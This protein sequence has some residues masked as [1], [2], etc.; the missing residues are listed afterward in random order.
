[1]SLAGLRSQ[2]LEDEYAAFCEGVKRLCKVDLSSYKRAQMERRIRT[3]ADGRGKP[4][5]LDYLALLAHDPGELDRFLDRVTINVS[6]LWRNPTQWQTLAEQVIPCLGAEGLVRAWSAGCSYGAELFTIAAICR[7]VVPDARLELRG[8]D[9]DERVVTRARAGRFS[10]SDMRSVPPSSRE[11]WFEPAD[12]GWRAREELRS[13]TRFEVEDLLECRPPVA[14]Y[15]LVCCRNTV[16]YF[17]EASRAALHAKLAGSL[18]PGGW[19]MVG[20]TER[21]DNHDEIGLD[22]VY[23]FT[24]RKS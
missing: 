15:D 12:D 24:Y 20:S 1:M 21:V 19:L 22:L 14:H 2:P 10:E 7:E 6:Q 8:S 11:R 4:A 5:L 18:R 13:L 9:I 17:N 23:P 3:F 16:I